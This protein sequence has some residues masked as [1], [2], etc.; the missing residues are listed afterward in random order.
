M[1][2]YEQTRVLE[3]GVPA[4]FTKMT[5]NALRTTITKGQLNK[6]KMFPQI[7]NEHV[8]SS[9]EI[10]GTVT[11][12]NIVGQIFKASKDN[13]TSL[14]LTLESAAGVVVDNFESYVADANL[15][16]AWVASADLAVLDT[17]FVTE[18]T[19]SMALPDDTLGGT[20]T[21]TVTSTDYTGYVF[22]LD[23]NFTK[24]HNRLKVSLFIGDG[25]NTKSIDL[26]FVA[27]G[28]TY[29]FDINEAAMADD[30]AGVTDITAI[31]KIG[32]IITDSDVGEFAYI[33]NFIAT[34]PGGSVD[35]KLW[36]M[37]TELPVAGVAT[38]VSG[39]QYTQI[40]D[41]G[42]AV[43]N[44]ALV[45]GKRL[46]NIHDFHCGR[47]KAVPTNEVLNVDHYY[48]LTINYVDTNVSVFGPNTGFSYNYYTNGYAITAPDEATA[49]TQVGPFS[50]LQFMIFSTQ[51]VYVTEVEWKFNAQPGENSDIAVYLEDLTM[52]ITD[53]VV[54]HEESPSQVSEENVSARP[55]LLVDGGKV[56]FYYGDDFT[57]S[58][59]KVT[60]EV[61]FFFDPNGTHG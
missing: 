43:H 15:Q 17:V 31:T 27:S 29:H 12:S 44:E 46:Y 48:L 16:A 6:I 25:T 61:K 11:A 58:T 22:S 33:D 38:I 8:E 59:T 32:F 35:L 57:D 41:T 47:D 4:T 45:G 1:S 60:T 26:T 23:S 37:G 10:Q 30:Q 36:D 52:S 34:P 54:N 7:L 42:A 39:T 18:G 2:S 56:E 3:I 49:I 53:V 40:G 51:E 9:R 24:A 21:K 55:M 5:E 28:Q 50:D 14:G 13:I 20:W 19:Q